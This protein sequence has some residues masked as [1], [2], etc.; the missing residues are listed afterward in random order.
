M[1]NQEL[2]A[3]KQPLLMPHLLSLSHTFMSIG[4]TKRCSCLLS[5]QYYHQYK[6]L[7]ISSVVY[8]SAV[9][10]T[11]WREPLCGG[12]GEWCQLLLDV[13]LVLSPLGHDPH[14]SVNN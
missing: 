14:I 12:G 6:P 2:M 7:Q 5:S 4:V 10:T 11:V 1:G 13:T 3:A 8:I 9:V